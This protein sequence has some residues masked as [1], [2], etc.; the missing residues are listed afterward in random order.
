MMIPGYVLYDFGANYATHVVDGQ[1]W[2][3]ASSIVLHGGLVHLVFNSL[4]LLSI[5]IY[6]EPV[7]GHSKYLLVYVLT[8]TLASLA[9]VYA[10][11]DH[12][13]PSVGASGAL[14]GLYGFFLALLTTNLFHKEFRN[15][16]F[17]STLTF[18]VL[19]LAIGY[20]IPIIDNSAHLGGFASGMLLG[21]LAYPWLKTKIRSQ[22]QEMLEAFIRQQEKPNDLD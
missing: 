19:N 13:V 21:Y 9:S 17:K 22:Q 14:F 16:F 10:H 15:R 6:I 11:L 20:A 8:G 2:R 7:L 4:V 1:W 12:P 18:V 3:L 5:G